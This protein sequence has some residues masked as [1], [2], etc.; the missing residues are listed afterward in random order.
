MESSICV[1]ECWVRLLIRWV[2]LCK[3]F[4]CL[5]KMKYRILSEID[6]GVV[7]CILGQHKGYVRETDVYGL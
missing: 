1:H 7:L 6:H 2:S 4:E 5:C 3:H